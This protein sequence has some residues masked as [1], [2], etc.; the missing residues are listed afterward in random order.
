MDLGLSAAHELDVAMPVA[1]TTREAIQALIGN[2][3]TDCDFS[4]LIEMVARN[5]ALEIKS[6]DV[7]VETGL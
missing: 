5:S 7:E 1:V 4:A 2:G 6:E 3:F